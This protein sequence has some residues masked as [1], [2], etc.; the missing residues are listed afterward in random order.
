MFGYNYKLN[1]RSCIDEIGINYV[2][3]QI[4]P[5]LKAKHFPKNPA[6]Q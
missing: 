1:Q 2:S 6:E 5:L 3:V 4:Q